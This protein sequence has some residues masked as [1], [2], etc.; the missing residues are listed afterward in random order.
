MSQFKIV[1]IASRISPQL[2][3]KHIIFI[4]HRIQSS[5]LPPKTIS[6]I[7]VS[8]KLL[9]ELIAS[10][11]GMW[12]GLQCSYHNIQVIHLQSLLVFCLLLE[13]PQ[14]SV[15]SNM[16]QL[17]LCIFCECLCR[18]ELLLFLLERPLIIQFFL[19]TYC[20]PML[21]PHDRL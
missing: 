2:K 13:H 12:G 17:R 1:N 21:R 15:F 18:T 6:R 10:P 11:I 3:K 20:L 19:S 8:T 16:F 4:I 7:C 9:G 5:F 14:L